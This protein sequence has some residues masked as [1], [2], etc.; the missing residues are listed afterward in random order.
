MSL[1]FSNK[2]VVIMGLGIAGGGAGAAKFFSEHGASVMVTDLKLKSQLEPSISS[3][4]TY[5]IEY[6]LGRH[7]HKDFKTADLIIRNPFVRHDSV[8]I[9]T[10]RSYGVPVEMSESLFM[11]LS[12]T[13]VQITP[14]GIILSDTAVVHWF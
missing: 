1:D 13:K 10:A 5:S 12:P 2:K 8:Y 6:I 7:R 4:S 14:I 9:Q 3:L 11:K